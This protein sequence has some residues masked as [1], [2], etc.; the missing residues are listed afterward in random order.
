MS[1][2]NNQTI[3]LEKVTVKDID[4]YL[5]IEKSVIGPKTYSGIKDENEAKEEFRNNQIYFIKK[6]GKIVGTIQYEMKSHDHAYLSGLVIDPH[7]QGQGIGCEASKLILNKLKN[8]KRI[9]VVTH[10]DNAAA[11]KLYQSLGFIIESR[12]ENYY[13]DGEPRLVLVLEK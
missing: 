3:L 9:N 11:L 5:A 4:Q 12:K 2:K 6:D 1:Q 7:F 8:M 10:P 13:G